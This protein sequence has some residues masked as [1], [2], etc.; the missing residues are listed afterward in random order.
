MLE[1]LKRTSNLFMFQ[2]LKEPFVHDL[3]ITRDGNVFVVDINNNVVKCCDSEGLILKK[4]PKKWTFKPI[5]LCELYTGEML[6]VEMNK[7]GRGKISSLK[8][9]LSNKDGANKEVL[10]SLKK[11]CVVRQMPEDRKRFYCGDSAGFVHRV[12]LK[13]PEMY[14]KFHSVLPRVYHMAAAN[15]L[16]AVNDGNV[17]GQKCSYIRKFWKFDPCLFVW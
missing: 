11:I 6:V 14:H 9:S 5:R 17:Q 10:R 16:I 12:N 15:S 8:R 3:S 1:C 2:E 7:C 4:T 13:S